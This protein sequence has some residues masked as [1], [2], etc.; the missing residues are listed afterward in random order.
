MQ[1]K[2]KAQ[3]RRDRVMEQMAAMQR[4]FLEKNKEELEEVDTGPD[5]GPDRNP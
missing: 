2:E 3:A 1:R 4:R 5:L